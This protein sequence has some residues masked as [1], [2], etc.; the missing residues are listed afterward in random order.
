MPQGSKKVTVKLFRNRAYSSAQPQV[1]GQAFHGLTFTGEQRT[2]NKGWDK[3]RTCLPVPRGPSFSSAPV[4]RSNT[5]RV[6]VF[7]AAAIQEVKKGVKAGKFKDRKE[8]LEPHRMAPSANPD[9][10]SKVRAMGT[11]SCEADLPAVVFALHRLRPDP[12][13]VCGVQ[14][15][16]LLRQ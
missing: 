12:R 13:P 16:S 10:Y 9:K 3:T 8:A 1:L 5:H 7:S 15:R 11:R 2:I 4:E 6:V 14:G